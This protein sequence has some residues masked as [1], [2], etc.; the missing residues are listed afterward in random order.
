VPLVA[1]GPDPNGLEQEL[2]R[3][4]ASFAS[5]A[6]EAEVVLSLPTELRNRIRRFEIE[7]TRSAGAVSLTDDA[8]KRR[9]VGLLASGDGQEAQDLLSPLYYLRRA[10]VPSA[11]L[12]DG[13][14]DDMLLASPDSAT[15][16]PTCW[17]IGS[18]RAV[19]SSASQAPAPPPPILKAPTR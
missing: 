8:L 19:C 9:E 5:G 12:I 13:A 1:Y 14:L 6:A 11:D 17:S 10:L 18:R 7:G 4:T 15:R 3:A 16:K 2:A